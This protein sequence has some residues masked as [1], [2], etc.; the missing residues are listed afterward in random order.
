[1]REKRKLLAGLSAAMIL[2]LGVYALLVFTGEDKKAD[3]GNRGNDNAASGT[4]AGDTAS[5]S[6]A[7]D[8]AS[9][10]AAGDIAS[11]TVTG[12]DSTG[13]NTEYELVPF[14]WEETERIDVDNAEGN[15]TIAGS[16]DGFVL[17]GYEKYAQNQEAMNTTVRLMTS[18]TAQR[19]YETDFEKEK[20]GLEEPRATVKLSGDME[21]VVF[22]LGDYNEG[23]SVWYLM[24]EGD[25]SLYSVAKGLGDKMTASL[26]TYLDTEL[27]PAFDSSREEM[28][29]RL[30]RIVIERPDLERPLEIVASGEPAQAYTSSYEL[31][32]PI[33][34]K[35]SLK[36]MNEEIGGLFGLSADR[37]TGIYEGEKAADYGLDEPV[38]V[39]TVCHDGKEDVFTVGKAV[40][41]TEEKT[42]GS[43][44]RYLVCSNSDLLYVIQESRLSFLDVDADDLF[45]EMAILPDINQVEELYLN[46]KG[47]EYVFSLSFEGEELKVELGQQEID[48]R[49]FRTFYSFLLEID[50]EKINTDAHSGTPVLTAEYRYREGGSD[51]VEAYQLED[52]RR[53]GIVVNGEPD[54]EGR[55]AYID[56]LQEE[57]AHLLAGE[58]IDTN[59]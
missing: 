58:D 13:E 32:S 12:E 55:I 34:V 8:T 3:N 41:E 4:V 10:S 18:L 19:I 27:I 35:T 9:G 30:T 11:G 6:A 17:V 48:D 2:L 51:R 14:T 43:V 22:Y 56:K 20:Y 47:E 29:E 1:M 42:G 46:L 5:G 45:F 15:Y 38:M 37:A 21:E 49:L 24:K 31:T 59:W 33:H 7:G 40:E 44:E 54:F 36:V 28:T 16:E 39:M 57:L 25:E 26:F 23:A 53:M 50:I 52:A